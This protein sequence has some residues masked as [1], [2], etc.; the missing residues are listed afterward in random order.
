MRDDLGAPSRRSALVTL[1]GLRAI[2]RRHAKCRAHG[3]RGGSA[4][5][6]SARQSGGRRESDTFRA[7]R[8]GE[9]AERPA[10]RVAWLERQRCGGEA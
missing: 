2:C 1:P 9:G 10:A 7:E 6:I 4:D 5:V 8:L 3:D